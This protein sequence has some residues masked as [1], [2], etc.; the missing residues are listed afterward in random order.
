M[1]VT[2]RSR[3]NPCQHIT[4]GLN[5]SRWSLPQFHNRQSNYPHYVRIVCVNDLLQR[6]KLCLVARHG[7][8]QAPSPVSTSTNPHQP[9]NAPIRSGTHILNGTNL[10]I[11]SYRRHDED[12]E[13]SG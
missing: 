10:G 6:L 3:G 12:E 7:E 1:G 11:W 8:R 13:T 2:D 4:D 5:N 9:I